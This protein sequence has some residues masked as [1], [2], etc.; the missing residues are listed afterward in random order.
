MSKKRRGGEGRRREGLEEVAVVWRKQ[1]RDASETGVCRFELRK[2][3]SDK[4][5]RSG[6]EVLWKVQA[7]FSSCCSR[8]Q[9]LGRSRRE[10]RGNVRESSSSTHVPF[11][12]VA[13]EEDEKQ[14][15]GGDHIQIVV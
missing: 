12:A 2:L 1:I 10:A 14:E 8:K 9:G 3:P 11:S 7:S 4:G 13:G 15:Y 5:V 6:G